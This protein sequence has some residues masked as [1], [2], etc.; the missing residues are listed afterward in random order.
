MQI[1]KCERLRTCEHMFDSP[2]QTIYHDLKLHI[3]SQLVGFTKHL[4]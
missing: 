4:S 3:H 2:G 1:C